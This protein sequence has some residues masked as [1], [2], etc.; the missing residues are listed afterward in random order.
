MR[1]TVAYV[2]CAHI[3]A[4]GYSC[5]LALQRLDI[6]KY[7][8]AN[9]IEVSRIYSDKG[10]SG[11]TL[12]RPDL[13]RLLEDAEQGRFGVILFTLPDRISR[14]IMDWYEIHTFFERLGIDVIYVK[15]GKIPSL[16]KDRQ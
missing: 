9:G 3:P 2:R 11:R 15:T 5:Q 16:S 7:A 8:Q 4:D 12:D 13:Q 1:K 6:R 10:F 14:S